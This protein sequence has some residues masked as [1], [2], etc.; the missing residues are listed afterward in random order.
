MLVRPVEGPTYSWHTFA[1]LLMLAGLAFQ[2]FAK[3]TL[4]RRFGAVAANRGICDSGP[5]QIVRHPIYLGYMATHVGFLLVE[6][7]WW[8][9]SVYALFYAV[10]IPRI[11]A[12]ERLL[13][14]DRAYAEY[15]Q[16]VQYRLIPGVF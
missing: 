3:Y 8:N 6:C 16:R 5:Y 1:A 11:L 15:R 14:Q 2:I 9:L 13:T 4:G 10:L 7:S 12:E